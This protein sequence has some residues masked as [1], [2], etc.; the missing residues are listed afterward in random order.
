[1]TTSPSRAG[2]VIDRLRK[3]PDATIDYSDLPPLGEDFF[4]AAEWLMPAGKSDVSLRLDKDLL[5]FF[6][7][8]GKGYQSRINA[9]LR[10]YMIGVLGREKSGS[11]SR[12]F[13]HRKRPQG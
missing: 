3:E 13:S 10:A 7:R 2:M 12:K 4:C 9:V 5:D 6:R 8:S 11:R 1:M